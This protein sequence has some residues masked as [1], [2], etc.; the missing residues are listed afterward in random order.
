VAKT[1]SLLG[2][3]R[4]TIKSLLADITSHNLPWEYIPT[5]DYFMASWMPCC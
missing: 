2:G 1:Y 5:G 3:Y 4:M